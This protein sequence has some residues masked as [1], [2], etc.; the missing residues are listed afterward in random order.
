MVEYYISACIND[1]RL[2]TEWFPMQ[3]S[4]NE[5]SDAATLEYER[6]VFMDCIRDDCANVDCPKGVPMPMVCVPLWGSHECRYVSAYI[7]TLKVPAKITS[8]SVICI[9]LL[10]LLTYLSR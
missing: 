2:N 10:T 7:L 4:E 3:N 1:I 9:Y 8:E 6:N 5:Q